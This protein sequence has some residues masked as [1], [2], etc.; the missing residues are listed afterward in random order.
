MTESKHTKLRLP[1]A[2]H[3]WNG[4]HIAYI[5]PAD[6]TQTVGDKDEYAVCYG[7]S[8]GTDELARANE[9]I[10][11][12][13]SHARLTAINEELVGALQKVQPRFLNFQR[14]W[15]K[16]LWSIEDQEALIAINSAL[17]K[18]EAILNKSK[19]SS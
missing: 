19:E 16:R 14:T 7:A 12:C 5:G 1:L 3:R 6:S 17:E 8:E 11:A 13:N 15:S 2:I 4:E 18:A 10:E 9:I